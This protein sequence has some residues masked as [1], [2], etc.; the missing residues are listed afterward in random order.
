MMNGMPESEPATA[1]NPNGRS[2]VRSTLRGDCARCFGLC[3]VAL[4]FAASAD[5]AVD[6]A[7]GTP[8]PNLTAENRCGVHG[9]LRRR[10]FTGCAVYDCFGAG[11]QVSNETFDGRDWRDGP[12]SRARSVFEVFTVV[13]QLREMLWYL[14]EAMDL[15]AARPLRAELSR[16]RRQT[17]RLTAGTPGDLVALDVAAHREGVGALLRRASEL[18]RSG[19][20]GRRPGVVGTSSIGARLRGADFHRADLRGACLV[21]A[22]L[23]DADLRRADLLG[24]DLRGASL[25]GA[26]LTGAFFL[27]QPQLEAA[28]GDSRTR[29]PATDSLARPAHWT[30]DA[31]AR[32]PIPLGDR[33]GRPDSGRR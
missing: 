8:C 18:V 3:C 6:K 20:R 25:A 9:S 31:L 1:E 7:A 23:A 21:A 17:E 12:P 5:F 2:G 28:R 15:P 27:T 29:L 26:D 24:A 4:P 32:S 33:R 13:R 30:D 16:V 14:T 22:D 10:G 11:Q 19:G